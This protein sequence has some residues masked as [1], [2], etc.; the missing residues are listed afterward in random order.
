MNF[1]LLPSARRP[2]SVGR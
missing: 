1:G 2:T